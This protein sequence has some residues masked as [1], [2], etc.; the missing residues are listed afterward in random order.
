MNEH[1]DF[2]IGAPLLLPNQLPRPEI[3]SN[4]GFDDSGLARNSTNFIQNVFNIFMCRETP[5]FSCS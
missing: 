4:L 3:T 5:S 1:Q 2:D